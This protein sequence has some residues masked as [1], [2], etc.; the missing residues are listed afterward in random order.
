[1]RGWIFLA[2]LVLAVIGWVLSLAVNW[3][4]PSKTAAK[5]SCLVALVGFSMSAGAIIL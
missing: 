5:N 4:A 3:N 1:V 2:G